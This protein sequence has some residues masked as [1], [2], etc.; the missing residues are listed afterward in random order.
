MPR[1]LVCVGDLEFTSTAATSSQAILDGLEHFKCAAGKITVMRLH[2]KT[3][4]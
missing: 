2:L 1:F 3:A 4:P